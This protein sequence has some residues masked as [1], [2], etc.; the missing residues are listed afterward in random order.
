MIKSILITFLLLTAST[1]AQPFQDVE[2]RKFVRCFGQFVGDVPSQDD[3]IMKA[4]KAKEMTGTQGC[5]LLLEFAELQEN[6]EIIKVGDNYHPIGMKVIKRFDDFHRTWFG[7]FRYSDIESPATSSDIFNEYGQGALYLTRALFDRGRDYKTIVTDDVHPKAIRYSAFPEHKGAPHPRYVPV[8]MQNA[9]KNIY[10]LL[11]GNH[12]AGETRD[13]VQPN[14]EYERNELGRLVG[15]VDKPSQITSDPL[16]AQSGIHTGI[17]QVVENVDLHAHNGGGII[18]SQSYIAL[19]SGHEPYTKMNGGLHMPRRWVIN[20]FN[21]ILCRQL[22]AIRALDAVK[23]VYKNKEDPDDKSEL[24]FRNGLSCMQCHSTMEGSARTLR[25]MHQFRSTN[26]YN[27]GLGHSPNLILHKVVHEEFADKFDDNRFYIQDKYQGAPNVHYYTHSP[28]EGNLYFRSFTGDLIDQNV[29]GLTG[30]GDALSQ[31]PDLYACAVKRYV[32][33][34]TG[35]QVP[36]R[37]YGNLSH[38]QLT[39]AE[40]TYVAFLKELTKDL[41][42]HQDPFKTIEAII[43]SP[44]YLNPNTEGAAP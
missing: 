41:Q 17:G 38:P 16:H 35:I 4:I 23:N 31:T 21:D 9:W 12:Y 33:F 19:N 40:E 34:L 15:I 1:W 2:A 36:L 25:N 26:V 5:M 32:S 43:E 42:Q 18:G 28:P 7:A 39:E 22:P 11:M 27:S 44:Y 30:L 24:A 13:S 29:D 14:T 37:D 20:F 3:P 6:G 10:I 8:P